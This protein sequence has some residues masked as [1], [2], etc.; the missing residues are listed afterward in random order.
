MFCLSVEVRKKIL[1]TD[2]KWDPPLKFTLYNI[3]Q[4]SSGPVLRV[5]HLVKDSSNLS[6][7]EVVGEGLHRAEVGVTSSIT[8]ILDPMRTQDFQQFFFSV[9]AVGEDHIFPAKP[10]PVFSNATNVTFTYVP[11]L[12][13]EYDLYV[14]E[15]FQRPPWQKQ[16]PGSPFLLVVQGHHELDIDDFKVRTDKLPSC[17]IIS[18]EDPSWV[19]GEWVTRKLLGRKRGV[20]RSGWVFQPKRCSFDIFTKDD[21]EI[22]AASKVPKTIAIL[23]SSTERGIFLSLVDLALRKE[24]KIHLVE[25]DLAKCWGFSEFQFGNLHFIYQD[26]RVYRARDL[27]AEGS[28]RGVN[29]TCNNEK[30]VQEGS[31]FFQDALNF[32]EE[33]LFGSRPWPDIIFVTSPIVHLRL[34]LEKIPHFWNGTIYPVVNFKCKWL[35][36]YQLDGLLK[37]RDE[38]KASRSLDPR[39]GVLD[40]FTLSTG[41]RHAT[42][43]SPFITHSIHFHRWCDELNGEMRVCSNPTE[44]VAQFLLGQAIAPEGKDV[45][46]KST[47]YKNREAV[48]SAN[49]R[50]IRVC[51]DCP[52]TLLPFHIKSKP[53]LNCYDSREGLHIS[54]EQNFKVWD[55]SPCPEE[56]MKTEPV[57][58]VY[59]QSGLVDVRQ[60]TIR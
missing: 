22:A 19:E 59:T 45:W 55:G 37:A 14:E 10:Q 2:S 39:V 58:K 8:V 35:N 18:Q 49:T 43:S 20:L 34:L 6:T 51:H 32:L 23:G 15:I 48:L 57:D 60:C 42:E 29:V 31:N 26:F 38:A 17:Q 24:E 28:I 25:S 5:Q 3:E 56:C 41:M 13:G 12:P 52:A 54:L 4:F 53:D 16:V 30:K 36:Y 40:G 50:T 27:Y 21:I 9:L 33:T 47:D 11:T 44:M 46:M 1:L 7:C